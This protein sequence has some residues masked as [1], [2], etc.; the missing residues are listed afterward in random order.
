MLAD[1]VD[2]AI[3]IGASYIGGIITEYCWI[4][5]HHDNHHKGQR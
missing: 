4:A 1:L 5:M 2:A 3:V